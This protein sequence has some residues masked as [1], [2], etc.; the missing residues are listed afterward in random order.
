VCADGGVFVAKRR[1][2]HLFIEGPKAIE[3]AKRLEPHRGTLR[4]SG[5]I[6]KRRCLRFGAS[7]KEQL[8]HQV[9]LRP[10]GRVQ[11]RRELGVVKL[12]QIQRWA[13]RRHA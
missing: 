10:V 7:F 11:G 9:P 12:T 6:L 8:L 4:A 1:E 13:R 5:H 2:Q 3:R